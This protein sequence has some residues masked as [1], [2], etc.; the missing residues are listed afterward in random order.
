MAS[1]IAGQSTIGHWTVVASNATGSSAAPLASCASTPAVAGAMQKTILTAVKIA[2][3][4]G[5]VF[6]IVDAVGN[7]KIEIK[8][9][10][11]LPGTSALTPALK[12]RIA[13]IAAYLKKKTDETPSICGPAT[14]ADIA[15]LRSK[16]PEADK[17]TALKSA[18]ARILSVR[19]ELTTVHGIPAKRLFVCT[20]EFT[21][22]PEQQPIVT[23][24]RK[25]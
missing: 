24:G 7:P 18:E 12:N 13:E 17:A 3:P 6:A 1:F 5:T 14:V 21:D 15:A 25:S 2:F 9:L 22:T 23:V 8:P 16:N 4:L 11:F 19:D 20:P 10:A